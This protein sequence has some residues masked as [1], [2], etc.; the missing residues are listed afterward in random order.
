MK[1]RVAAHLPPA[2]ANQTLLEYLSNRFAYHTLAEWQAKIHSGEIALNGKVVQE[3]QTILQ[4]N[5]LL[6]Y[7]PE[8]L[9]E[10]QVNANYQ[11]LFEDEYLLVIDKP[12]NLPVHPA[13]PYFSNTLWA[14][15]ADAG[16]GK[17]HLVNRLDRET[18]GLL[19]AA[20][21]GNIAGTISKSMAEMEKC[22]CVLV[23]G[24][25]TGERDVK[26]FLQNDTTS[27][28]RKKQK[29]VFSPENAGE[30][31]QSA[32]TLFTPLL[33][34]ES[35]TLLGARL[36]TGRMHQIRATL[37]ALGYPVV[38]DKLYGLDEQFYRRFAL[39]TL[40]EEDRQTLI[41]DRQALHCCR[42]SFVHPVSG[43]TLTFSSTLP[44]EISTL[45]TGSMED[46]SENTETWQLLP[47]SSSNLNDADNID[48]NA[49]FSK[50]DPDRQKDELIFDFS[51]LLEEDD[52]NVCDPTSRIEE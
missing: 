5:M 32:E 1:R 14:M 17:V 11:I 29:F 38:G 44:E 50:L 35:F 21:H 18:S 2:A 47:D 33:G 42:L 26:G 22:Y 12:G 30:K 36:R 49:I 8:N 41:L 9:I 52:D 25:F 27:P 7:F 43:Q 4:E 16:Y 20:K 45:L 40:S 19:I 48:I 3:P 24:V 51:D 15:L 6:E 37:H 13:G 46:E 28:V 23:H 10:P 39:D 31:A 34:N